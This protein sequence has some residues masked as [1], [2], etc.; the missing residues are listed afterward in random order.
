[1]MVRRLFLIFLILLTLM[2]TA[3]AC[4][5]DD[6]EYDTGI[7]TVVVDVIDTEQDA[8]EY[9]DCQPPAE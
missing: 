5:E 6:D 4:T 7:G 3:E 9:E 8:R 1:M 2:C